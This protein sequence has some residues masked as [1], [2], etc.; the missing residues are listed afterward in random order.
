MY[1]FCS[2]LML[3]VVQAA[4]LMTKG[5]L[6]P[7]KDYRY[8]PLRGTREDAWKRA[9]AF[10]PKKNKLPLDAF[11]PFEIEIS[12]EGVCS[13]W[14]DLLS[15]E[16]GDSPYRFRLNGTLYLKFPTPHSLP[17]YTVYLKLGSK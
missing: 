8:W 9:I 3:W 13:L 2:L 17:L 15:V 5:L 11:L 16:P 4:T 1:F 12:P 14:P 10:Y 7:D 6:L